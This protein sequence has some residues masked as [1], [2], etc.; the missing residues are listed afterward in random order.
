MWAI[1]TTTNLSNLLSPNRTQRQEPWHLQNVKYSIMHTKPS[2]INITDMCT[3]RPLIKSLFLSLTNISWRTFLTLL[4]KFILI[5]SC[6]EARSESFVATSS[7][8]VPEVMG[9]R[10]Q[11][12]RSYCQMN[13]FRVDNLT[14]NLAVT[15]EG[16][17][18]EHFKQWKFSLYKDCL[19]VK[20]DV[21]I[22]KWNANRF[23]F[24]K[25]K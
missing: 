20:R 22:C 6:T 19:H 11:K 10:Y 18:V 1:K 3:E 15:T 23:Y 4:S 14:N 5:M 21:Q 12:H 16:R 24:L 17:C 2:V 7:C 13:F 9:M 25:K 8:A